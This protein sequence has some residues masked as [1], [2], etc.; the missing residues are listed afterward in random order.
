MSS[1]DHNGAHVSLAGGSRPAGDSESG[2]HNGR[3]GEKLK[4]QDLVSPIYLGMEREREKSEEEEE[5]YKGS[6]T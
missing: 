6:E 1:S 4:G 3:D 5:E 2:E